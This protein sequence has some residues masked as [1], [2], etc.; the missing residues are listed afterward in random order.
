MKIKWLDP[1]PLRAALEEMTRK[2]AAQ[3]DPGARSAWGEARAI[4]DTALADAAN[5][6]LASGVDPETFGSMCDPPITADAVRKRVR[7]QGWIEKGIAE[8]RKGDIYIFPKK[9]ETAA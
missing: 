8:K 7:R 9:A 6:E 5:P 3:N 1:A 4:L 2:E